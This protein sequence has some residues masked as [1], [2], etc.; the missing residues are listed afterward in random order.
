MKKDKEKKKKK[1]SDER[2][3]QKFFENSEKK[4]NILQCTFAKGKDCYNFIFYEFPREIQSKRISKIDL[5][6]MK[7]KT[8]ESINCSLEKTISIKKIAIL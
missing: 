1:K 3:L 6:F 5:R 8:S 7:Y 2:N 4:K